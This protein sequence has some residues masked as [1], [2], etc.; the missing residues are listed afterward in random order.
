MVG[1]HGDPFD[2]P[3]FYAL[4]GK[5]ISTKRLPRH[6]VPRNDI[7]RVLLV[8]IRAKDLLSFSVRM[9]NA[10]DGFFWTHLFFF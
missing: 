2:M 6:F 8:V 1:V 10:F 7:V 4:R 5:F 3:M 9:R